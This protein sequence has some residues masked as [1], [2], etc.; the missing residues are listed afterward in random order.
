MSQRLLLRPMTL[1][2]LDDV[3]NLDRRAFGESG[4]SRRYFE[5]ELTQSPISVFYVLADGQ[6][7]IMGYFGT[8]H[9]VDQLHLCT[10]AVD[11]DR[12]GQGLGALLLGCVI[13][14][15]QRL[16]CL[17]IQLEVRESNAVARSLYRSRG[18]TEEA[19]RS[20]LY[21][22]PR[23]DGVLMGMPTPEQPEL[24]DQSAWQRFEARWPGG[25]S[26][27]WD[28]RGGQLEERWPIR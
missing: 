10:F 28:D 2:D 12:Q 3:A 7:R 27:R 16:N 19:I 18:F 6:H 1:D 17:V 14:L 15:A 8:W 26:L 9:V 20:N 4:W 13:R 24:L 5:G 25:L 22:N 21:A 23:E 11:P